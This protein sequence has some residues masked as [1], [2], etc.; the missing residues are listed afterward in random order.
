MELDPLPSLPTASTRHLNPGGPAPFSSLMASFNSLTL[1]APTLEWG[2][3]GWGLPEDRRREEKHSRRAERKL[4]RKSEFRH[5]VYL[6]NLGLVLVAGVV[7]V[8]EEEDKVV[9]EEAAPA[10]S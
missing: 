3:R 9:V 10:A 6:R 4:S 5:C 8:E 1:C 7:V 2:G